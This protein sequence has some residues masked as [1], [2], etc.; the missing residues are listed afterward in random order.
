MNATLKLKL[1]LSTFPIKDPVVR[2]I[3]PR[4]FI[5][6]FHTFT[7][8]EINSTKINPLNAR[9]Y[10]STYGSFAFICICTTNPLHSLELKST[11]LKLTKSR[12]SFIFSRGSF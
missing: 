3:F 11:A 4:V 9:S 12:K 8:I 2:T 5:D 6:P 1:A 7:T 10:F